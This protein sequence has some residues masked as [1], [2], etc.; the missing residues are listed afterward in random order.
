MGQVLQDI[1]LGFQKGAKGY[2]LWDLVA[3]K[4]VISRYAI[5][6]E[7]S[8]IKTFRKEEESQVVGSSSDSGK[9]VMQVELDEVESQLKKEPYI[10]D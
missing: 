6:V 9:L 10:C 4:V 5:F 7:K 3:K 2:K 1:F 8:M